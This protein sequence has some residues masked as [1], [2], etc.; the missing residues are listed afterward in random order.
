MVYQPKVQ[1]EKIDTHSDDAADRLPLALAQEIQLAALEAKTER[2]QGLEDALWDLM[3][4]R[5]L[6]L[7]SGTTLDFW[8]AL[9]GEPREGLSDASYRLFVKGRIR[10]RNSDGTPDEIIEI[11]QLITQASR[12]Y[13]F[14]FGRLTWRVDYIRPSPYGTVE[15]GKVVRLLKAASPITT[16]VQVV[17]GIATPF[18]LA[19]SGGSETDPGS[20]GLDSGILATR[21]DDNG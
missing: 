4:S 15:R 5:Q 19:G 18:G 3:V 1:P 8:G 14:E 21:I 16:T 10:A 2:F 7:C 12:C 6:D 11:A 20:S 17:E 13:L 9:A